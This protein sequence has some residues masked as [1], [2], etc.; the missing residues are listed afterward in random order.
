MSEPT[1]AALPGAVIYTHPTDYVWVGKADPLKLGQAPSVTAL[2]SGRNLL[3]SQD[4]P[5]NVAAFRAGPGGKHGLRNGQPLGLIDGYLI[6]ADRF[7]DA[8]RLGFDRVP[9]SFHNNVP[10]V[11]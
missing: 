9:V 1:L 8:R 4:P 2:E 3:L 6:P 11:R 7:A 10:P 5:I